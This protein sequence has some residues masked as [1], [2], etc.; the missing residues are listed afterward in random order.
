MEIVVEEEDWERDVWIAVDLE[1]AILANACR[2]AQ[3]PRIG[4][5]GM[6]PGVGDVLS[7]LRPAD[8]CLFIGILV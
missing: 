3:R 5:A 2:V 7:L 4:D 8:L 1:A 6:T